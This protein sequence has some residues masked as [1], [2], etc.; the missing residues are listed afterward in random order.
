MRTE[1]YN[2]DDLNSTMCKVAKSQIKHIRV[3]SIDT[4][5]TTVELNV[6][7]GKVMKKGKLKKK[8]RKYGRKQLYYI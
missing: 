1:S 3:L 2:N 7:W 5:H 6:I 8:R 4:L